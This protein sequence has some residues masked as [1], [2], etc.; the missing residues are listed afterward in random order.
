VSPFPGPARE[1]GT[2]SPSRIGLTWPLGSISGWGVF[3]TNLALAL[4]ARGGPAP[5]LLTV[6]RELHVD[7]VAAH[8][9]A[10][11]AI[12]ADGVQ[13]R[14]QS[15]G[16]RLQAA[17]PVLY[18]AGNDLDAFAAERYR[19]TPD[20][21][22]VFLEDTRLT[23]EGRRR[24]GRYAR[25]LAGSTW[26]RAVLEAAGVERVGTALQGIDPG[27]FHPAPR[28]GVWADRFVVFSGGKLE[29]RKGQDLVL[30]AFRAFHA[31][32]PDALLVT[33]WHNPWPKTAASIAGSR[34]VGAAPAVAG[35]GRLDIAAWLRSE[36]LPETAAIDLGMFPNNDHPAVLR[37]ADVAVFPNR[38]EGGTNLVAME[39]MAVGLPV[40]LSDNTGH[41]DLIDD[42]R[43]CLP[44]RRQSAVQ[45]E[46]MG[47][48][49]W[50]ESDVEE[51]LDR[52]EWVYAHR[53]E[54]AAVGRAA[55]DWMAR[56]WSW[57]RRT[58]EIVAEVARAG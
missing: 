5:C 24:A 18:A 27:L 13:R 50:G 14:L 38:C 22:V 45:G 31:R 54:A 51:I 33:A 55:A 35:D 43:V 37:E 41:R 32:H 39:A 30:G 23:G 11:Y 48:E 46:G 3:G 25:I 40:I 26:C 42:G 28:S 52:L 7:P 57:A 36:G 34:H 56:E 49:G 2:P 20:I 15:E 17:F 19:G 58:D 44:L 21:A 16:G 53:A 12:A 4:L 9:L 1:T 29:F 10:P 6:P 8:R 47:A